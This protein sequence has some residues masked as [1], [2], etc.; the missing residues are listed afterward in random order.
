M[1]VTPLLDISD[2]GFLVEAG[3]AGDRLAFSKRDA[4]IDVGEPLGYT[5]SQE[6]WKM[7]PVLWARVLF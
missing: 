3:S 6:F 1:T 2:L 4:L 5:H 7:S